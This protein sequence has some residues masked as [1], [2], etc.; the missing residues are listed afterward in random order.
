MSFDDLLEDCAEG[1]RDDCNCDDQC[2]YKDDEGW[3]AL[4]HILL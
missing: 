1:I 2:D 4:F 3:Q